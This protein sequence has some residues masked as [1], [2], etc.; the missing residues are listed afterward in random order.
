MKEVNSNLS[1]PH[2]SRTT[3][4]TGSR[5]GKKLTQ[6][7]EDLYSLQHRQNNFVRNFAQE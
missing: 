5:A 6:D 1:D 3:K 2:K 7:P 4:P